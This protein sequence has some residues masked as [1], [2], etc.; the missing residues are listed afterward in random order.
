MPTMCLPPFH[1]YKFIKCAHFS[2]PECGQQTQRQAE[3]AENQDTS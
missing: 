1:F 3:R 2:P